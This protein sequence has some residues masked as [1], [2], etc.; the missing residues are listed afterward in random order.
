MANYPDFSKYSIDELLEALRSIDE[1]KHPERMR[2]ILIQLKAKGWK[3]EAESQADTSPKILSW[4]EKLCLISCCIFFLAL[5]VNGIVTGEVS[6]KGGEDY[7]LEKS[8]TMF[9]F[10]LG[11]YGVLIGASVYTLVK[12]YINAT[13]NRE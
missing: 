12:G 4:F 9:Y 8:P 13:R 7:S 10:I 5:M 1:H 3:P 2:I 11:V 6:P